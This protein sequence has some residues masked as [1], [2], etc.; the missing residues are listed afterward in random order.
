MRGVDGAFLLFSLTELET[1]SHLTEW[2]NKLESFSP[3]AVVFLVGN[4]SDKSDRAIESDTA[5][6]FAQKNSWIYHETCAQ[7]GSG[8][9]ELF[10][11]MLGEMAIRSPIKKDTTK[12][13]SITLVPPPD[14]PT[15]GT[16]GKCNNC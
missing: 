1:F 5:T 4:K 8:V 14:T 7:G 13:T 11:A 15:K 16:K 12:G 9:N 2:K 10:E 3:G 6:N